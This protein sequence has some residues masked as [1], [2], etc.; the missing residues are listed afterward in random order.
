MVRGFSNVKIISLFTVQ[1]RN[2]SMHF[3]LCQKHVSTEA[4]DT[5]NHNGRPQWFLQCS[6]L[7]QQ[8]KKHTD[9]M[10]AM[11]YF[12]VKDMIPAR[13]IKMFH[14]TSRLNRV[15]LVTNSQAINISLRWH[16]LY[17]QCRETVEY[18]FHTLYYIGFVFKSQ[19]S[20]EHFF[21]TVLYF[22]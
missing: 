9:I 6:D 3:K 17:T 16:Q 1:Q 4:G 5:T 21:E 22:L 8:M 10:N 19:I 15:T 13:A 14:L 20:Y 2:S 7:S 18:L 11:A 12:S